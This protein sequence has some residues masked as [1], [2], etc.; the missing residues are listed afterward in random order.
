MEMVRLPKL[1]FTAFSLLMITAVGSLPVFALEKTKVECKSENY[2]QSTCSVGGQIRSVRLAKRKSDAACTLDRSYGFSGDT[3]WVNH[4]CSGEF[5]VEYQ[6][7]GGVTGGWWNDIGSDQDE[8]TTI[9][10]KSDNYRRKTCN[11]GGTVTGVILKDRKSRSTC[12]FGV[13]YGFDRD[14]IWVDRGCEGRFE[15]TYRLASDWEEDDEDRPWWETLGNRDTE[16]TD[17]RCG[18]QNYGRN[19]CVTNGW[20]THLRL[21]RQRS[22]ARCES[23][24]SYGFYE[25]FV[26]VDN[27]CEGDFEVTYRAEASGPTQPGN[28]P[29]QEPRKETD[30]V[31][32]TCKSEDYKRNI[33][34]VGGSIIDADLRK[35]RSNAPCE[36]GRTYGYERDFVWVD[37]GCEAEFEINYRIDESNPDWNPSQN[38]QSKRRVTCK[39]DN[40]QPNRCSVG[41]PILEI[42][43]RKNKSRAPCTD[44]AS[45]G[46]LGDEIWVT[47]GCEGEFEV[48][49]VKRP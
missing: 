15:V 49:Y 4:G 23:G 5:E 24:E 33:C 16:K 14:Y 20:I 35:R 44:G 47:D 28:D 1:I 21:K 42:R 32:F 18:S 25:D 34:F 26:W 27:G 7:S 8:R 2:R 40:Y 22:G 38:Q 17:V 43:L 11:I 29:W 39:S 37:Q 48:F 6:P 10:C 3:L 13:S 31:R 9:D 36:E 46:F 30:R 41:G 12:D 19:I 45:Y